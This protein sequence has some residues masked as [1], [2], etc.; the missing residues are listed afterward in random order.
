MNLELLSM[1]EKIDILL[2]RYFCGEASEEDLRELDQWLAES[3]EHEAY[4]EK[5]TLIFQHSAQT[6]PMPAPNT[7]KALSSFMNYIEKD[8]TVPVKSLFQRITPYLSAAASIILLI[9]IA[10]FIV[11]SY[12][13]LIEITAPQATVEQTLYNGVDVRLTA[14]TELKYNP[15]NN[16]QIILTRG[17][18]AFTVNSSESDKLKVQVNNAFIED[19]GTTFTIIA[20]NPEESITVEVTEGEIL[21]YTKNNAGIRVKQS[22]KGIY[23]P[24]S[25]YFELITPVENI[26]AIE[27]NATPLA[28][29]VDILSSQYKVNIETSSPALN[30]L[31]ISVSFDPN[32]TIDNILDIISKTLSIHVIKKSDEWY[33]LSE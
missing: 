17:E 23:H 9:G 12:D 29:V 2:S 20:H 27:F 32:E 8:K 7:E 11:K 18:A 13:N 21:F 1:D 31:Q 33:V 4:F 15:E 10:L 25:D 6:K 16:K 26:K 19:I 24:Q 22:E 3:E 28:E 5:M 30:Q 14:G